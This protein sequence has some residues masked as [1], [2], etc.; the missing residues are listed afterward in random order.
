M[1]DIF[2]VVSLIKCFALL[3]MQAKIRN[4]FLQFDAVCFTSHL[5][6]SQ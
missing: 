5:C 6:T 2:L 3:W 1:I 4:N